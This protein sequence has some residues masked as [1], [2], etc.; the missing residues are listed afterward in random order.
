MSSG[1]EVSVTDDDCYLKEILFLV[2]SLS[3]V[4]CL[5]SSLQQ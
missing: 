2:A 1:S 4:L 3:E 5:T